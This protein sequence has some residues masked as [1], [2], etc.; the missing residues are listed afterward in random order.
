MTNIP[1]FMLKAL[2]VKGSLS[3]DENGFEFKMKNELG[4]VRI[5][6]VNPL[7]LDRRP[8]PLEKCSFVHEDLIAGFKDVSVENSVLMRKGESLTLRIEDLALKRGRHTLSINVIVKDMGA[9]KFSVSDQ[10]K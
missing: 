4:P 10:V 5:I 8:I 2:Y 6:G 1:G 3:A 7:Q 9:V